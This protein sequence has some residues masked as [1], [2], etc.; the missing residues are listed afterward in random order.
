MNN[1]AFSLT[2]RF[3]SFKYAFDGIKILFKNEHN[4]RIHVFFAVCAIL[5]GYFLNISALEWIVIVLS[6]GIV[7][8]FEAINTAVEKLADFISPEWDKE[9][10]VVKDLAAASVLFVT[11]SAIVVAIIIFYLKL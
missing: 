1:K 7:L 3:K 11:I 8:A 6:I 2:S 10:K 4:A 9:I 5:G